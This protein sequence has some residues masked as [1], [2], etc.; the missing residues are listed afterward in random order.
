[1]APRPYLVQSTASAA[2][3][4]PEL[5]IETD[6]IEGVYREMSARSA[7]LLHPNLRAITCRP[8]G[9]REF[10]ML[11]STTVCVVFRE[12]PQTS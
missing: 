12:W 8:W 3:D 6:D 9:A 5:A 1:M 7:D 10:A 2:R 4:R 11:D